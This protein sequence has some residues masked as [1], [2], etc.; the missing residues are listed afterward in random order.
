[1]NDKR[2]EAEV[3]LDVMMERVETHPRQAASCTYVMSHGEDNLRQQLC[4]LREP[5][6]SL[7]PPPGLYSVLYTLYSNFVRVPC[8]LSQPQE[9][10]LLGRTQQCPLQFASACR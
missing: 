10:K 8:S 3:N 1:M 4:S 7:A 2:S 5:R 6:V 9:L